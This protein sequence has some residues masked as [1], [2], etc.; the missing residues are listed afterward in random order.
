MDAERI[1]EL[2]AKGFVVSDDPDEF[3]DDLLDWE[4]CQNPDF[5]AAMEHIVDAID[6]TDFDFSQVKVVND[7]FIPPQE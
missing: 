6:N 2:E 7:I 4:L 5:I 1:K 3:L